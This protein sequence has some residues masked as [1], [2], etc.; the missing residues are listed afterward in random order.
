MTLVCV[1]FLRDISVED[2]YT[3]IILNLKSCLKKRSIEIAPPSCLRILWIC[4]VKLFESIISVPSTEEVELDR[5][6]IKCWVLKYFDLE[7]VSLVSVRLI[8]L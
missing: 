7:L 1:E 2:R 3:E 6:Y 8:I 5:W 4:S